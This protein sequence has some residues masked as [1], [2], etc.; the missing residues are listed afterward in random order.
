MD[1]ANNLTL[2]WT[3][4]KRISDLTYHDRNEPGVY[5]W[6]FTIDNVFI[7]YYVGIADN[8]IFR[9]HEHINSIISG[10]Y[11][12]FHRNSLATFKNFK[13]QDVQQDKTKGK[14][15]IPDWPYGFKNFLDNRKELQP[16]IDFMVD[17][18]TFSYA[19]V[20]RDKVSGQDL[21][22]I[23]KICINQIGKENLANTRAGHSD[24]FII[25]H[26]GNLTIT[27]IIKATNR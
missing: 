8:I 19:V 9:I 6:G 16:H 2:T 25:N 24:K 26:I 13:D 18:F 12:I 14:I 11:T 17:T 23:E 22:D 15:Y 5:V 4:P 3:D 27:E 20:D 10:R 7:P 21:K 1:L